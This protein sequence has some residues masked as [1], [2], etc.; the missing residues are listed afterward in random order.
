VKDRHLQ[1]IHHALF[2]ALGR[3]VSLQSLRAWIASFALFQM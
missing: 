3:R 2:V 1:N